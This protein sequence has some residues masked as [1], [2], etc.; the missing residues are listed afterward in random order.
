MENSTC[1]I[2]SAIAGESYLSIQFTLGAVLAHEEVS[3]LIYGHICGEL[4]DLELVR[5]AH[6]GGNVH[7]ER[8]VGDML[9]VELDTNTVLACKQ[10]SQQLFMA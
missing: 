4:L 9:V 7:F 8:R 1:N 3:G 5:V 6:G 10:E 2:D